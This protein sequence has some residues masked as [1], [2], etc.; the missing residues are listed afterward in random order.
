MIY[1]ISGPSKSGKTFVANSLRNNALQQKTSAL[2]IDD[3]DKGELEPL[4]EKILSGRLDK[5]KKV[6]EMSWKAYPVVIVVGSA[7]EAVLG[8]IEEMLPGFTKKHGPVV[9]LKLEL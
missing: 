6:N 5:S 7:G 2:M 4:V 8:K 3:D 9:K 1:V